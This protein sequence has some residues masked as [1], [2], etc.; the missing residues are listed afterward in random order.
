ML[1]ARFETDA[2]PKSW[3][4]EDHRDHMPRQQG[5]SRVRVF[6]LRFQ[7]H[8]IRKNLMNFIRRV[9]EQR[10]QMPQGSLPTQ[11]TKQKTAT[12]SAAVQFVGQLSV[13][14]VKYDGRQLPP[15]NQVIVAIFRRITF[16]KQ[17]IVDRVWQKAANL[18]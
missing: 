5:F 8:S 6:E 18:G 12:S 7:I 13:L 4:L 11:T 1:H 14:L 17:A 16:W 10:K 2:G 15:I 9:I 3:L